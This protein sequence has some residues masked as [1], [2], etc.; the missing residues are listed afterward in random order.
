MEENLLIDKNISIFD[1]HAHYDDEEFDED[2]DLI[3]EEIKK[4]DV[5]GVL[6][7]GASLEG[8]IESVKLADKY[9]F[10]Y[11]AVGIHPEHA[12][13][14]D[15]HVV[16]Q[17]RELANNNKV[18]A[19]GEIGLDYYYDE[20]PD[21]ETQRKAFIKQMELAKELNLP[22]IIHD[23]DAHEDT[24]KIIKQFPGVTG[25]IH[26][27]SGSLEFAKE[28]LKLGY[29][30]GVTG[31]VT[32]KNARKIIEVVKEIPLDRI[33]IETDCPYMAPTPYRGK[34]NR[35]DYIKYIMEKIAEIKGLEVDEISSVSIF[36]TKSL[37]NI[38][39]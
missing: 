36:N 4:N 8:C 25:E 18:K 30:I 1:A 2:R 11:A 23:R 28:C 3:I 26:C 20:N 15:E 34:R 33:L 10:F 13:D 16:N 5:I 17:L 21:R 24:L 12:D 35:S 7:C 29:Y 37:L 32:F 38:Q 27:F 39:K 22:V 9:E 14:L 19:I 31:V 6:N